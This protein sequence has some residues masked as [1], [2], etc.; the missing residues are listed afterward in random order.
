MGNID[1]Y[2]EESRG[3]WEGYTLCP[4]NS[5]EWVLF[6]DHEEEV[7]RLNKEVESL[8]KTITRLELTLENKSMSGDSPLFAADCYYEI[9]S[10][11]G[12]EDGGSVIESVNAL[13]DQCNV[14]CE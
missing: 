14:F 12:T 7:E 5:G 3:A 2:R 6:D 11:V 10:I 4:D 8:N 13:V 9:A 1:R